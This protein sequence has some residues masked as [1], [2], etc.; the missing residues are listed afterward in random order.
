MEKKKALEIEENNY[1][2]VS[3]AQ[4]PLFPWGERFIRKKMDFLLLIMATHWIPSNKHTLKPKEQHF[5]PDSALPGIP[6]AWAKPTKH[7]KLPWQSCASKAQV[8]SQEWQIK[9]R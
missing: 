3:Y 7:T 5:T 4:K 1:S 9:G 6:A 2:C 8:W